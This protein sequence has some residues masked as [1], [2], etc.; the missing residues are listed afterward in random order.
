MCYTECCKNVLALA[1]HCLTETSGE[2]AFRLA[3]NVLTLL[4]AYDTISVLQPCT[5]VVQMHFKLASLKP[6]L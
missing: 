6:D 3:V 4:Y 5:T 1:S 2:C